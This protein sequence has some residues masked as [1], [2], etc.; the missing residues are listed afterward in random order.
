[1]KL[2]W[3]TSAGLDQQFRG[4]KEESPWNLT[5]IP[6]TFHI[7]G[8][9]FSETSDGRACSFVRLRS[10]S[11]DPGWAKLL[12]VCLLVLCSEHSA[13]SLPGAGDYQYQTPCWAA[14]V[15]QRWRF[16]GLSVWAGLRRH[17]RGSIMPPERCKNS[18]ACILYFMYKYKYNV[19]I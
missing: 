14:Q 18:S 2:C 16:R 1:M 11:C 7:L 13:P 17:V 5:K 4:T 3:F 19:R 12:S 10:L 6:I 8:I 15:Q 9:L